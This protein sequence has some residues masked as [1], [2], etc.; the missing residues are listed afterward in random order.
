MNNT[1]QIQENVKCLAVLLTQPCR[2]T[3]ENF[4]EREIAAHG[5]DYFRTMQRAAFK[6]IL[7]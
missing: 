3:Y 7:R 6:H 5:Y 4:R 2:R 1:R